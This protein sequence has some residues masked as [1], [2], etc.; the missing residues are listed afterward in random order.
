MQTG[1]DSGAC[2][3]LGRSVSGF[4]SKIPQHQNLSRLLY[5]VTRN[6]DCW[7]CKTYAQ[8][9]YAFIA[10]LFSVFVFTK[11]FTKMPLFPLIP[12]FHSSVHLGS[13]KTYVGAQKAHFPARYQIGVNLN[14]AT[15]LA[16]SERIVSC[17]FQ[18]TICFNIP[19]VYLFI[20]LFAYLFIYLFILRNRHAI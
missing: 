18:W 2:G 8:I 5:S 4:T 20:Y 19:S 15:H 10:Q 14:T 3:R 12:K 16:K 7:T 13:F 11:K 9:S 1:D 6:S 17:D